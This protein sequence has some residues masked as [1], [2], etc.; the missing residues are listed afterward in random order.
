MQASIKTRLRHLTE[1]AMTDL[2]HNEFL[3]QFAALVTAAR[4]EERQRACRIILE[5]EGNM[6]CDQVR[7][8][9]SMLVDM[10]MDEMKIVR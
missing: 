3:D 1:R 10:I 8:R 5:F 9:K 7:E 2:P 4:L 6:N